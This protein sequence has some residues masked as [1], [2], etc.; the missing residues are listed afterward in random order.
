M[1]CGSVHLSY[2]VGA[3]ALI[4]LFWLGRPVQGAAQLS[5]E[6]VSGRW[7]EGSR[8][9]IGAGTTIVHSKF[10]GQIFGFDIDQNGTEGVLSEA[11]D[12]GGGKVLAA[13]E[14][15]DQASGKILNV[16]S[17]I[18]TKDD[19]LTLGIVGTS[20]GLV[21]REHV[22]GIFV[23]QRIYEELNPLASN[24]FTGKWTPPLA[25][26]DIIIGLSRNQ[27]ST[28]TA[29]LYFE[30]DGNNFSSF[31]FGSNVGRIRSN[32]LLI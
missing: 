12:I 2:R 7:G 26:D 6:R 17:K 18:E 20:V 1:K 21:E 14:T 27:A 31:V 11:Q 19:F 15:F 32:R 5:G 9:P 23:S 29:V 13:V 22:Q 16:V 30:N 10:G 3:V 28:T 25:S 24:K 4:C 8:A